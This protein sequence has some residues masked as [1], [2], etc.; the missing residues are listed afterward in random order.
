[1]LNY[2]TQTSVFF[3]NPFLIRTFNL[4]VKIKLYSQERFTQQQHFQKKKNMNKV[5]IKQ[6]IEKETK[7][8]MSN[9][10]NLPSSKSH[11]LVQSA[12]SKHCLSVIL[13]RKSIKN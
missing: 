3:S 11:S 2:Q 4:T 7:K 6:M 12:F 1:M 8:L 9:I 10:P 13:N 5:S